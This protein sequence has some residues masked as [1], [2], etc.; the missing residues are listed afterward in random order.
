MD[1]MN[2]FKL[3][4]PRWISKA[5][6]EMKKEWEAENRKLK[7]GSGNTKVKKGKTGESGGSADLAGGST[8]VSSGAINVNGM[9]AG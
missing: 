9:Y 5:E 1:A 7:K 3:E 8:Q 2:Q 4:V 6:G